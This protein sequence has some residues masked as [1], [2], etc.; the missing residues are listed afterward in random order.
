M[1][2]QSADPKAVLVTGSTS[3][4]GK[5]TVELLSSEGIY[6]YAGGRRQADLDMLDAMD[7]VE[8]VRLDVTKPEDIAAAVAQIEKGGKGLPGR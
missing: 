8:S 6:V 4:I 7:N 3:G 5:R 1:P 2:A